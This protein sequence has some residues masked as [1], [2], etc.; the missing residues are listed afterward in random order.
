[1]AWQSNKQK[2]EILEEYMT[3]RNLHI[4]NEESEKTSFYNIRGSS[5]IDLTIVNNQLLNVLK[6]WEISA[7]E[8][9]S[10]RNIIKFNLRQDTYYN[11]EYN[12]IGRRYIVR[13]GNL[14]TLDSNLRWI[15]SMKF[16]MGQGNT[17]K[18]DRVLA[19]QVVETNDIER[20][21]NLFPDASILSCN[22]YFKKRNATKTTNRKSVPWWTEEIPLMRK[23]IDALRRRFQRTINNNDLR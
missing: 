19:S 20:A 8:T 11:T 22:K 16:C 9:C 6:N 1:M 4:M 3:S 17:S 5:N 12:Y 23:R 10:D 13:D 15:V 14:K 7:E 18:P 2:G 21:F